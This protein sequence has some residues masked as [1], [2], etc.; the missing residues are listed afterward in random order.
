[1][2]TTHAGEYEGTLAIS[3]NA[4]GQPLAVPVSGRV[5]NSGPILTLK[6]KAPKK[7][8]AGKRLAVT[9][10]LKNIGDT[11]SAPVVLRSHDGTEK[12]M[13]YWR[14]PERLFDEPDEF[15]AWA[16]RAVDVAIRADAGK[17]GRAG[18]KKPAGTASG[19]LIQD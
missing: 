12:P 4:S 16:L 9:V 8:K 10:T 6:V 19:G 13:P 7:V 2:L 5:R 14:A 18:K 1:M 15:R 11:D 3:S 17:A